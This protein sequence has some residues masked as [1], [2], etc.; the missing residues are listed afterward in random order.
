MPPKKIMFVRYINAQCIVWEFSSFK[1]AIKYVY[2]NCGIS[3][4]R[5]LNRCRQR[6]HRQIKDAIAN[7]ENYCGGQWIE[8]NK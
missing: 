1:Q 8:V 6:I 5:K 3:T 7:K 2:E 4:N